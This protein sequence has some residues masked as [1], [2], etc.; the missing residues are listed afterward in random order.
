MTFRR[1]DASI[2]VGESVS[3]S[4]GSTSSDRERVD[5]AAAGRAPRPA[6][7]RSPST[8]SR[9]PPT[10][11]PIAGSGRYAASASISGA[12]LTSALS[13]IPGIDAWPLR[14]CTR[15]RNGA[16]IFSALAQR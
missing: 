9:K 6:G 13:A 4:S 5:R 7:G 8:A 15:S 10:S 11:G 12:A 3:E 14:P 2:I 16:V 1:S